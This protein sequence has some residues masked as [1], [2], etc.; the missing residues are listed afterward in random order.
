MTFLACFAPSPKVTLRE[1][2]RRVVQALSIVHAQGLVHGRI[3]AENILTD[4]GE[5]PDFLRVSNGVSG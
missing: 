5:D 1:C 4:A 3:G 2:I